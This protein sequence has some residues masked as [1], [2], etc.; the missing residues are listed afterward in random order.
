MSGIAGTARNELANASAAASQNNFYTFATRELISQN[1]AAEHALL[2]ACEARRL[3]L[4]ACWQ[5]SGDAKLLARIAWV[6]NAPIDGYR[7]WWSTASHTSWLTTAARI[8]DWCCNGSE[9]NE[10]SNDTQ[11][12]AF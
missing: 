5:A 4:A 9:K 12:N 2:P 6:D 8:S 3:A 11:G 10:E 7:W 1:L